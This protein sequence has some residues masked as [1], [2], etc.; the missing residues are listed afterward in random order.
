MGF[1]RMLSITRDG[2]ATSST[3]RE[4]KIENSS[5][6]SGEAKTFDQHD[7]HCCCFQ[8]DQK[9]LALS[10]RFQI[11]SAEQVFVKIIFKTKK[12]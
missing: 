8:A 4:K 12:T 10:V 11:E 7:M 9:K 6:S 1:S 5:S 2:N 3:K